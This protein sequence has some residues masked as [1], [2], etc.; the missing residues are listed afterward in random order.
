MSS[1][2]DTGKEEKEERE[3]D[4]HRLS[5]ASAPRSLSRRDE[6]GRASR[7]IPFQSKLNSTG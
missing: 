3:D 1:T 4:T 5:F 6:I 2:V 7:S